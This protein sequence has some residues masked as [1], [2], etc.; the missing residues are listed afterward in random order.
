MAEAKTTQRT[1]PPRTGT[2]RQQ[3]RRSGAAAATPAPAKPAAARASSPLGGG[4]GGR[5]RG[6]NIVVFIREVRSELR[7]VVWPSPADA[8]NLTVVVL[9]LSIT[10]GLLLGAFDYL[11][12]ELFRLL[13][14]T[15]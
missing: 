14:T 6:G 11:F 10:M 4:G 9:A 1:N 5:R 2:N 7:K 15:N 3:S 13:V 8:R 12:Q